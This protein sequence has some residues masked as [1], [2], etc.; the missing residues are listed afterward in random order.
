METYE[1]NK[2]NWDII[3]RRDT[4][5]KIKSHMKNLFEDKRE[6][7]VSDEESFK[8]IFL[9]HSKDKIKGKPQLISQTQKKITLIR[10]AVKTHKDKITKEEKRI[11][12]FYFF[13]DNFDKRYD[14][15]QKS[16]FSM[17]FWLY[18]VISK[19]GKEYYIW[20]E[21][22]LPYQ[23]CTFKGMLVELEDFAEI[24]R[25]MRIKSLSRIFILRDFE[26]NVKVLDKKEIIGFTKQRNISKEDWYVF[27][28]FHKTGNINIFFKN[29]N[30]LH[31]QVV[32]GANSRAKSLVPSFRERPA[33]IG[34]FAKTERVGFIDEIFKMVEN[35]LNKHQAMS[36]NIFGEWNDL[37]D[38][39][40]RTVGSGNDNDVEIEARAK[41]IF[42]SNPLLRKKTLYDHVG[43]G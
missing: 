13:D 10:K 16:S 24:S 2:L 27:L 26:P 9:S 34:Y 5:Q 39:K 38:N 43:C 35:E 19:E 23:E 21:K 18:R 29:T 36:S 31:E 28:N 32:G 1:E 41:F 3:K 6:Y 37:L 40:R 7:H 8:W 25:S 15:V 33:N 42:A 30:E 17:D 12:S 4:W 14:G 11:K 20:S 22:K